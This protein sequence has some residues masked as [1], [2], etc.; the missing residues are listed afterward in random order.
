MIFKPRR[1]KRQERDS[2]NTEGLRNLY[3]EMFDSPDA[4]GSAFRFME[5]E[6]VLVLDDIIVEHYNWRPVV[7]LAYTSKSV[8]DLLGLPTKSAFRVGK[9][10]R[11]SAPS[12]EKRMFIVKNLI[13]RGVTRIAVSMKYVEFDTDNYL[14][15]DSLYVH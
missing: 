10:V 12:P 14:Y 3:W 6:P 8:A 7:E 13:L 1:F 2:F 11:L 9:A 5:R 15:K 4:E